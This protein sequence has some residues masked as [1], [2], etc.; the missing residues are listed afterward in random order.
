VSELFERIRNVLYQCYDRSELVGV[1]YEPDV[2]EVG[3]IRGIDGDNFRLERI[4]RY[5]QNWGNF[6]GT[7]DKVMRVQ[8][9]TQ[10]MQAVQLLLERQKMPQPERGAPASLEIEKILAYVNEHNIL[11]G[12]HNEEGT[13]TY[14]FV[15]A[16]SDDHV[17][18][19]EINFL[20]YEDGFRVFPIEDITRVSYGGPDEEARSFLTRVRLGL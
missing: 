5:G 10:Y 2:F 7:L 14:G 3:F 20:G 8:Y 17:E 15:R 13:V 6:V 12:I 19:E 1:H 4:D 16:Y 9:G 11:A 18:V